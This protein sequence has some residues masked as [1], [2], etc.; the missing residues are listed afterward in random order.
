MFMKSHEEMIQS[1]Y[2][3][4]EAYERKKL[5]RKRATIRVTGI[6]AC[7][8]L[9][10]AVLLGSYG[11]SEPPVTPTVSEEPEQSLQSESSA[12]DSFAEGSSEQPDVSSLPP[13]ESSEDPDNPSLPPEESERTPIY[14]EIRKVERDVL[15]PEGDIA[16]GIL[17]GGIFV[18]ESVNSTTFGQ[19][20]TL[21]M[22][23]KSDDQAYLFNVVVYMKVVGEG[24]GDGMLSDACAMITQDE[25]AGI[26][27]EDWL[28]VEWF[29]EGNAYYCRLTAREL[30][31][32]NSYGITCLYVGS[33]EGDLKQA[34]TQS[35]R[36]D[37]YCELYGDCLVG[38]KK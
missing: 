15:V 25:T 31:V 8:V 2:A 16:V 27:T 6:A 3:R 36:I 18:D 22:M 33:G 23:L 19:A 32:L 13:E 7:F 26:S 14:S 30:F 21:K 34:E 24:D 11:Q 1:L 38:V 20:L 28:P 29:T 35:E 9:C 10:T 12:G 37:A 4:R 5:K 17:G